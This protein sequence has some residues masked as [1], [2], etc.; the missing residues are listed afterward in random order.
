MLVDLHERIS[1]P[2]R[3][4]KVACLALNTSSLES[5]AALAA[6]AAAEAETGLAADDPVRFGSGKLLGVLIE[7]LGM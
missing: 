7:A 2:R 5:D 1:L 4:A 6:I 3:P